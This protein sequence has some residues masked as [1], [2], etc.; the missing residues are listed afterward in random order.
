MKE[1]EKEM[2]N[3]EGQR[4]RLK[5]KDKKLKTREVTRKAE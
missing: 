2:N 4:K 3:E 5:R 1:K